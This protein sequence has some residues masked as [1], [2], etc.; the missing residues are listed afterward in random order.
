MDGYLR[1]RDVFDA[2]ITIEDNMAVMVDYD[3]GAT[4]SYSLNAH[5]PWEGYRVVVNG[6]AGRAELDVVER[7]A[8]LL[9][10][11]GAVVLDPSAQPAGN[12]ADTVRPS[13]DRLIVQRHWETAEVVPIEHGSGS[14]GGGDEQMLADLF[15]RV[16]DDELDRPAGF[17]SG[18]RAVSVGI[19]G[20]RSMATQAVDPAHDPQGVVLAK[21]LGQARFRGVLESERPK[22]AAHRSGSHR[23]V[24]RGGRGPGAAM[25]LGP[26]HGH[27]RG[28]ARKQDPAG[29]SG[30]KL[31][32]VVHC[33]GGLGVQGGGEAAGQYCEGSVEIGDVQIAHEQ[34]RRAE[35][36]LEEGLGARLHGGG[37]RGQDR[38]PGIVAGA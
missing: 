11:D 19:A 16:T 24:R 18:V 36:L 3:S 31:H 27:A 38:R 33:L 17:A 6:T 7:G 20:N 30:E 2:D 4:M 5:S 1:D 35:Y 8:T 29:A 14:H 15:A 13:G 28:P 25:L 22:E 12:L 10:P 37:C 23:G 32:E 9:G 26:I 21:S 34:R